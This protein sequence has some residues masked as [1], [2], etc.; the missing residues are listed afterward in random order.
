MSHLMNLDSDI[1]DGSGMFA[2]LCVCVCVCVCVN[3]CVNVNVNVNV[4]VSSCQNSTVQ[5]HRH[6]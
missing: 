4:D 5:Y 2:V 1:H 6:G 3:V